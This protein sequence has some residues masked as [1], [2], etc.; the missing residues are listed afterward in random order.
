MKEFLKYRLVLT[1]SC[2][3]VLLISWPA[4]AQVGGSS[5][6]KNMGGALGA[7]G[8]DKTAT[9]FITLTCPSDGRE[10]QIGVTPQDIE[11]RSGTKKVVCPYDGTVFFPNLA[12]AEAPKE[13]KLTQVTVRC[14]ADG[15]EFKAEVNV[16]DLLTGRAGAVLRCPYDGTKF[17]LTVLGSPIGKPL[18]HDEMTTLESSGGGGPFRV[19]VDTGTPQ[20]FFSPFDGAS[21]STGRTAAVPLGVLE[22]A[23]KERAAMWPGIERQKL[24]RIEEIFVKG[25]SPGVSKDIRQFGYDIFP[26]YAGQTQSQDFPSSPGVSRATEGMLSEWTSHFQGIL[27]TGGS[28]L[29]PSGALPLQSAMSGMNTLSA[30]P[31]GSDYV[32]GPGD[33]LILNIWGAMQQ[34]IPV[35]VDADGKIML[36]KAGPVYVW[37]LTFVEAE[38]LIKTTLQ[39]HYA[40]FNIS[41]SMG[42]L[43]QIRIFVFGEVKVPGTYYLTPQ[44]T[45]LHALYAAY[46]PTKLGSLRQ[47]KLLRA[48]K[49][50]ER[51]DLYE[52][53]IKGNHRQD[54]PLKTN[55]TILVPPIGNVIGIAGNVKRPAIY[56][57]T[58]PISL[59]QLL[60]MGGG[61]SA[62]GFLQRIQ[63][64]RI[65]DRE[66]KV[67]QD[68]EF[69]LLEDLGRR[70]GSITL[71]D[72]D[73]VTIFPITS[74]RYNFVTV[75][76]NVARPGDYELKEKMRLRDLIEKAGGVL[77][78]TY[79]ERAELARYQSDKSRE[80]IRITLWKLLSGDES[81]NYPLKEWDA[82]TLYSKSDV[83]PTKFV[84]IS[85]AVYEPGKYELTEGMR[86]NDLLF[87]AGGL[88]QNA[89]LENAE[90][91]RITNEDSSKIIL[92]NLSEIL[93]KGGTEKDIPL[94]EGDRLFIRESLSRTQPGTATLSGEFEF[95]GQYAIR[96]G[97]TLSSVIRRAGGFTE[98]AFLNG[99]VFTRKALRETQRDRIKQFLESEQMTLLQ[100]QASLGAGYDTGQKASRLGLLEY[101]EKLMEGL[102]Q[103]E[104]LG[105]M[106]VKLAPP[107]A[108]EGT[109]A[110]ITMEDGDVL[111]IP[112]PPSSVLVVGN[113]YN[114]L[115]VTYVNGENTDYYLR[116]VGGLRK[117]ADKKRVY[118]IK[119]NGEAVGQFA[120]VKRIERGDTIVVP[121]EFK[122]KTPKMFFLKDTVNFLY[123]VAFGVVAF[124][125]AD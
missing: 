125:A 36:P 84:E 58:A 51:V 121:E 65:K 86:I 12:E 68:F 119:A 107:E 67:V 101:R 92:L 40:N 20:E 35:P 8:E 14:P 44:A 87:K 28:A 118:V 43:R 75:L 16:E 85:G 47:I 45:V 50:E 109:S 81:M 19:A 117:S 93:E 61:M 122:Y 10:F 42:R 77:P 71:Q 11:L 21:I 48:D 2:S 103:S 3:A 18:V 120:R 6:F 70:G 64:E 94:T 97:E 116:K 57:T 15:R 91:F 34:T 88:Q 29:G 52:I 89:S 104:F 110:D 96:T 79:M 123:Q 62:T 90:L 13:G 112:R 9:E 25:V 111:F 53:L 1:V 108:L 76:G 17:R 49:T 38:A 32:V 26:V 39:E 55:D 78:G 37:G 5:I 100:E 82:V 33:I 24:S 27:N 105:R 69:T 60:E 59:A 31:I 22:P 72:G 83:I 74:Q 30:I 46:G 113:V 80:I 66:R 23:T 102:D 63:I 98:N 4:F 106:I 56:E 114:P 95:P 54:L 7:Q 99:T 115:A 124:A 41:V 73:L